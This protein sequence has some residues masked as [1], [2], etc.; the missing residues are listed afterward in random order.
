MIKRRSSS[1]HDVGRESIEMTLPEVVEER[2]RQRSAHGRIPFSGC[3]V[4]PSYFRR[5]SIVLSKSFT[6]VG[7]KPVAKNEIIEFG[8]IIRWVG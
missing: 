4:R 6:V 8:S 2:C 1:V 7:P 5:D 3:D